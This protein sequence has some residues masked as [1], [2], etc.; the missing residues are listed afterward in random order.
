MES[1]RN[2]PSCGDVPRTLRAPP[3]VAVMGLSPI[4]SAHRL[5]RCGYHSLPAPPLNPGGPERLEA[6]EA[7]WRA[8]LHPAVRAAQFSGN[9]GS[10]SVLQ[11]K[12]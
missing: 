6:P 2:L 11:G 8:G 1:S 12:S 4:P 7:R 3:P 9:V 10:R 5:A